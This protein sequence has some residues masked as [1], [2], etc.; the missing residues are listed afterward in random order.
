MRRDVIDAAGDRSF[1]E[2]PVEQHRKNPE[3]VTHGRKYRDIYVS[4]L[5]FQSGARR[6]NIEGE[7]DSLVDLVTIKIRITV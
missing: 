2:F 7:I 4:D 3:N 6:W 1:D 5:G